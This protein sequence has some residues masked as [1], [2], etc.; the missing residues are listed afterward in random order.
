[1]NSK[2]RQRGLF[3]GILLGGIS[4]A[5]V[6]VM[7]AMNENMMYFYSPSQIASG[8][9]PLTRRFRVGGLVVPG[10]IVRG[11]G[12]HLRFELTDNRHTVSVHYT[13]L[14]P[15]LF[16]EGQ[17]I[18]ADGKWH[19]EAFVADRILAKHDENYMPPEVAAALQQ[20][21]TEQGSTTY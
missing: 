19:Q 17:G 8:E 11:E 15:D 20:E 14:L 13:G 5:A 3:V 10:S 9:L 2:Q 7:A 4:L 16:R 6:L 1:M 18:I 12:L 21:S